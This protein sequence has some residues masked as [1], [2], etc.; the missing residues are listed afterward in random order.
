MARRVWS[1]G[2]RPDAR[3][4][5]R[6]RRYPVQMVTRRGLEWLAAAADLPDR[7]REVWGDDPRRP[8][9]IPTGRTF[10]VVA[11]EQ[12]VGVETFDQLERHNMPVG[13]VMADWSAQQIGFFLPVGSRERFGR[14]LVDEAKETTPEY[15]YL[16]DGSLVVVPGPMPLSG[17]RYTWLRAPARQTEGTVSRV[18]ALAAMLVAA[19]ELVRSADRYG[20]TYARSAEGHGHER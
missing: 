9:A 14:M 12:R 11:L 2:I 13:P 3:T 6:P 4:G 10:D 19:S 18:A 1:H 15:R 5:R 7:C 8:Y 17:D 20:E 16:A